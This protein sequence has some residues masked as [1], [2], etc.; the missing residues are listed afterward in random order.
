MRPGIE[1]Q[2]PSLSSDE[3]S[4]GCP[5]RAGRRW[6]PVAAGRRWMPVPDWIALRPCR[7][8]DNARRGG[9]NV[10]RGWVGVRRA[11]LISPTGCFIRS[12]DNGA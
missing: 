9:D 8:G 7:G 2:R 5:S 4:A 6:V 10:S 12:F 1:G 3:L 11:R